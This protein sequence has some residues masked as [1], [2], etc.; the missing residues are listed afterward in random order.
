MAL[1]SDYTELRID[2]ERWLRTYD[3]D[4]KALLAGLGWLIIDMLKRYPKRPVV[5][6]FDEEVKHG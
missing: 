1:A 5:V 3:S 4:E 2:K 6:M